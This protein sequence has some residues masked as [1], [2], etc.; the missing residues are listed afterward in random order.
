LL[1]AFGIAWSIHKKAALEISNPKFEWIVTGDDNVSRQSSWLK[2][3]NQQTAV[4]AMLSKRV[5]L[6]PIT[7]D[8]MQAAS[9]QQT[10]AFDGLLAGQTVEKTND[11]HS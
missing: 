5:G 11:P 9:H 2:I 1:A 10:S 7:R 6:D 4:L 3:L 8:G